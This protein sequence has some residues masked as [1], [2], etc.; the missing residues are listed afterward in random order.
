[1]HQTHGRLMHRHTQQVFLLPTTQCSQDSLILFSAHTFI[2]STSP[3]FLSEACAIAPAVFGSPP[4]AF[5]FHGADP[6][7]PSSWPHCHP[8]SPD[9]I[10]P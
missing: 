3:V 2:F 5:P 10:P 6:P 4:S 1:M 9:Q 8:E 7:A